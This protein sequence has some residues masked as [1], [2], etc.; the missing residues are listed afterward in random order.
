M[1]KRVG[2]K[3][4]ILCVAL[5][6]AVTVYGQN[7]YKT[8]PLPKNISSR[9]EEYSGMAKYNGRVYLL[10][11]YGDHKTPVKKDNLK[12]EFQIYS[13]LQD[14]IDRVIEGRDTA[15]TGYKIFKVINLDKLPDNIGNEYEGFEAIS[16]VNNT[17]YLSIES[18]DKYENCYLLKAKLDTVNAQI[19]V[20]AAHIVS[21]K[22]PELIYNAGFEA[23]TWL[24]KEKKL[25]AYYE[26]NGM[27]GGG[28]GYLIDTS[29]TKQPQAI[30]TPQ[31]Y[32]RITDIAVTDKD[33]IYG[34]NY[35]WNGDYKYYL[36]N[37]KLNNQEDNIKKII[38]AL[39]DSLDK[40]P[41]YLKTPPTTFARIVSLKN[42]NAKKWE[43]VATFPGY[44]N[45]WEGIVLY[46]KGALI[47]T[48]ANGKS[49][50]ETVL[51]Y[52]GF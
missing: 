50:Q 15:L 42:R 2:F 18:D 17:V 38:P 13:L 49:S 29:F 43:Q 21:L 48:D 47:V 44:K 3:L 30:K 36:A 33:K 41:A 16:I 5:F 14:S 1:Y 22:R 12:G 25:L 27:P 31:L 46:R 7:H 20:D 24:P 6:C 35:F 34:I 52:V 4:L 19:I 32:F 8:I 10:P 23:V 37:P 51:A 26:Y 45:N 40:K 39:R 9:A 11:Q 28:M